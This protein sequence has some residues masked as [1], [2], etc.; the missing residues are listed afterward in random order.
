[1]EVSANI[2]DVMLE[3]LALQF[4]EHDN[5]YLDRIRR[6]Q[7]LGLGERDKYRTLAIKY[8]NERKR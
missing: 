7:D 5:R 8:A 2:Y 4:F 3:T 6:W 1:M